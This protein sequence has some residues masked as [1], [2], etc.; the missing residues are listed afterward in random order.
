[1]KAASLKERVAG[2]G[3]VAQIDPG[4][5][6]TER[7]IA[8]EW[9]RHN[10][11]RWCFDH[12][13]SR[14]FQFDGTRWQMDGVRGA[15]HSIGELAN[16]IGRGVKATGKAST[17]RGIEAF[18]QADPRIGVTHDIWD[19]S[20]MLLGTPA[21]TIDLN[22]GLLRA[23]RADEFVTRQTSVAPCEGTPARWLQFLDEATGGDA[24]L[25]R[26]LQQVLGYAL[27]GD[28]REHALFFIYG[29]GKNGK[30]VFLNTAAKILGDYA[31]T[32]AMDTFAAT[33]G[34][35]HPTELAR[36]DGAR[37]VSASETEEGRAWAEARIKQL[38]GGDPI[39]ARF[40][41]GDFFEFTPRFKLIIVGNHQPSL[42]NV[43]PAT[44]RRFNIIPFTRTP[45]KPD[46][47]LEQRLA[48]EHGMIL[49]WMIAGCR[50]WLNN[51]LLRPTAVSAATEDYFES[52]DI[53]GQ[54][55]SER[56][57]LGQSEW[58]QPT[59][60]FRDWADYAR[61]NGED[62][63]TNKSFGSK[64]EK[65]GFHAARRPGGIRCRRGISVRR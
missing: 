41:R 15:F 17:V 24:D 36:L 40:M 43:D 52:Q 11:D 8:M 22:T 50:D 45:A 53:L 62:P 9:A 47:L 46:A 31:M 23:A 2:L 28:T 64:L 14:W 59:V 6:P 38:T 4:T 55:V 65:R 3:A 32:A 48:E 49:N 26:F 54:W 42:H 29:A 30:S 51:G 33:R 39:A 61:A 12:G 16:R 35:R 57:M 5:E 25:T 56:C 13:I 10:A 44:R 60:L 21:G 7:F 37:L 63:G 58:E 19:R 20:P 27:T 1:V 34:D 18:A